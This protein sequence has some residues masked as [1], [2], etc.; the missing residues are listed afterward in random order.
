MHVRCSLTSCRLR[1]AG[2]VR[3]RRRMSHAT[4]SLRHPDSFVPLIEIS[5]HHY[6]A[7]DRGIPSRSSTTSISSIS[8]AIL[9]A[10][11]IKPQRSWQCPGL[12]RRLHANER[13]HH[14]VYCI[15]SLYPVDRNVY[16]RHLLLHVSM[17][18]EYRNLAVRTHAITTGAAGQCLI[19]N[20]FCQVVRHN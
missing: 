12:A 8:P 9:S 11:P 10:F 19:A 1:S 3:H 2:Q 14:P 4:F 16:R 7:N 6:R 17:H 13:D 18:K 5:Y 15:V 20:S